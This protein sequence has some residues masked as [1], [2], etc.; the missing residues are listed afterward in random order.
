[1][2]A[3]TAQFNNFNFLFDVDHPSADTRDI[4]QCKT[5]YMTASSSFPATVF[6]YDPGFQPRCGL[7][8]Q[9]TLN[10]PDY[11]GEGGFGIFKYE[12]EQGADASCKHEFIRSFGPDA[13][14]NLGVMAFGGLQTLTKHLDGVGVYHHQHLMDRQCFDASSDLVSVDLNSDAGPQ[15]F[16]FDIDRP[17]CLAFHEALRANPGITFAEVWSQSDKGLDP[18]LKTWESYA[19]LEQLLA[20]GWNPC[21]SQRFDDTPGVEK[22]EYANVLVESLFELTVHGQLADTLSV[23]ADGI[24]PTIEIRDRNP[25]GRW[26]W[27]PPYFDCIL[28]FWERKW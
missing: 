16:R 6:G 14:P 21:Y 2:S 11:S 12:K 10:V 27:V 24:W 9:C 20:S 18:E 26:E 13:M 3:C 17:T 25:T 22:Q 8:Y 1:M 28:M 19:W 15:T 23:W 7:K 5:T 4:S